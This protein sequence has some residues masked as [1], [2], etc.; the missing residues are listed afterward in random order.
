VVFPECKLGIFQ[1]VR[2]VSKT[3]QSIWQQ[4]LDQIWDFANFAK[5]HLKGAHQQVVDFLFP[6]I[7]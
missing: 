3:P 6:A 5:P 2:S 7:N 1:N 4:P